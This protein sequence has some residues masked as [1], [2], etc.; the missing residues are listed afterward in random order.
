MNDLS[1]LVWSG[2]FLPFDLQRKMLYAS[3]SRF[4]GPF[5]FLG[6]HYRRFVRLLDL[7]RENIWEENS[8]YQTGV[9]RAERKKKER[10]DR[11]KGKNLI[12]RVEERKR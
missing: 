3:P 5:K 12:E 1:L 8:V 10:M 2:F 7:D 11:L 4:L 9:S 6:L